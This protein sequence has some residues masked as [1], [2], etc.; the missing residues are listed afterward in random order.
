MGAIAVGWTVAGRETSRRTLAWQMGVFAVLG[1]APDLDLLIGRHSRETHSIGAAIIA[2]S[3]VALWRPPI[4]ETRW[5][6][7]LASCLAWFSHPIFD[8]LSPDSTPPLGVMMFWPFSREHWQ[9]GLEIFMPIWRDWNDPYFFP[10]NVYALLLEFAI[11][12]PLL[13]VVYRW[14][15]P[16]RQRFAEPQTETR[17]T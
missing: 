4:A 13:V 8:A 2:A 14:R 6:M 16:R 15:G 3:L 17:P 11:L 9:S 5:R 12:V 7:W 10:H 1:A